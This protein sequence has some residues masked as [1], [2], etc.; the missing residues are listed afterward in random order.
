MQQKCFDVFNQIQ[1]EGSTILFVSHDLGA[2][3]RF[4]DKTLLLGGGEQ[5]A[6]GETGAVLEDR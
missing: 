1:K 4:C 3:G 6:L 2:V 5:R